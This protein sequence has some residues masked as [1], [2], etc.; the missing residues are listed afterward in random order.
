L[1]RDVFAVSIG[2]RHRPR[3]PEGRDETLDQAN[4]TAAHLAGEIEVE[5]PRFGVEQVSSGP[6]HA[7]K[8]WHG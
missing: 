8:L 3:F 7:E 4:D 2:I 5:P 1:Q 6:R